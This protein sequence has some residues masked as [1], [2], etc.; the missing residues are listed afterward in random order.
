[1]AVDDADSCFSSRFAG[2]IFTQFFRLRRPIKGFRAQ[3][4]NFYRLFHDLAAI[5]SIARYAQP[6]EGGDFGVSKSG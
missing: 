4:R 2:L 5:A 6:C 3:A 1:M